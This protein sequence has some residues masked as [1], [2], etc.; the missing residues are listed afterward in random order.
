M[1]QRIQ[2]LYLLLTT[3]MSGLFLTGRIINFTEDNISTLNLDFS[4]I[5]RMS[6]N[7]ESLPLLS[8]LL[9]FIPLLS[10]IIIFLFKNRKLQ[11]KMTVFL[12]FII[13]VQIGLLAW[14]SYYVI[15]NFNAEINP[16]IKLILPVVE[17]TLAYLAYSGIRKDEELVRS[18][19]RL[20]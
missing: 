2:S 20:R 1:I 19:D 18:Y 9:A 14:Y 4:G 7:V 3:I 10:F 11:M 16:G 8:F 13:A 6:E 17:L 5:E 12:I 15:T